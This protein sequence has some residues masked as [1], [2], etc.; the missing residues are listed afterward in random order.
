MITRRLHYAWITLALCFLG[1]LAAQGM[2][3]SF[4]AFI[5]PWERS[6]A[7]DRSTISLVSSLSFVV[8]GLSQPVVGRLVDRYGVRRVLSGSVLLVGLS[9]MATA[10]VRSPLQLLL[11][12]GVVASLGFGGASGVAASV[13]VTTWFHTRRG[14]AFGIIEAGFGMGQLVLVPTSLVLI[15]VWGWQRTLLALGAC[16]AL[17]VFPLL[18]MLLRS[19]PADVGLQP[20]GADSI[21][22]RRA[23]EQRANTSVPAT[24]RQALVRSRAFWSLAVPFFICGVTTTGMI[25]THLI[26]FA[27]HHGYSTA[28]TGAAV[29]LL[30]AFNILGTLASGPLADRWDNRR[31]LGVL[32]SVRAVSLVLLLTVQHA[33]WLLAFGVLFGIVDFAVLA[34]TQLLASRYFDGHSL[35]FIFGLLSMVHQLGSAL[36]AYVPGVLYDL[37][38]SYAVPFAAGAAILVVG[39]ALSFALPRPARRVRHLTPATSA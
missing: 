31:I 21:T 20:Y 38:G 36:G 11:L 13:A 23:G 10:F 34:P 28:V 24:E 7:V 39:A 12:Y 22:D 14:L 4:G 9:V 25:D 37:T 16:T 3:L 29:S 15:A 27:Q 2:R 8:Y 18:V 35:G 33:Q 19:I 17:V 26:P 6:F 5:A 30:A 32:Y 1:L